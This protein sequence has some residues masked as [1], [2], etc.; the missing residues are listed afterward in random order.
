MRLAGG[1]LPV[2][3][4]LSLKHAAI[5]EG[6]SAYQ[7]GRDRMI[8]EQRLARATTLAKEAIRSVNKPR[9]IGRPFLGT[10]A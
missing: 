1:N 9:P 4:C 3:S 6:Q 8:V 7:H 2:R 5:V 10:T